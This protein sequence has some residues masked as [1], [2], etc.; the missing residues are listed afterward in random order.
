[1]GRCG[2]RHGA[3][4]PWAGPSGFGQ[5]WLQFEAMATS[6]DATQKR[7]GRPGP[8]VPSVMGTITEE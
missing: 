5:Y 3:S 1:M 7:R 6:S 4:S 8:A 2:P